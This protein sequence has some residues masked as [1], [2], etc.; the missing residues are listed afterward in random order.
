MRCYLNALLVKDFQVNDWSAF[1]V[2]QCIFI[3]KVS[4]SPNKTSSFNSNFLLSHFNFEGLNFFNQPLNTSLTKQY[5]LKI[6]T[7]L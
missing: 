6:K 5:N 7:L 4:L 1:E 2:K 3:A